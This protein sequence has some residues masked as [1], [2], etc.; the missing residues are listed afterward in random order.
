MRTQLNVAMRDGRWEE[1][2]RLQN[3]DIPQVERQIAAAEEDEE[4]PLEPM[5]AE[6]V[7]PSEV[8][9]VVEAWT[10]I[11]TGKLLEGEQDKLLHMED[12]IG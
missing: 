12:V 1:A 10:G 5:I 8:A 4:T 11:P 3:G 7:G 2:G 6:K 9:E